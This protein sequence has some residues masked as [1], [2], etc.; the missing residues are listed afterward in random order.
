MKWSIVTYR[1]YCSRNTV[2]H[3]LI[4]LVLAMHDN[5][6]LSIISLLGTKTESSLDK[7]G[8]ENSWRDMS[9]RVSVYL[10]WRSY[11][12]MCPHPLLVCYASF[13]T[14]QNAPKPWQAC[15]GHWLK[16]P[17]CV[18]Y[19]THPKTWPTLS[20]RLRRVWTSVSLWA[21]WSFFNSRFH[22]YLTSWKMRTLTAS[23]IT[24]ILFF[25]T[26][27]I[28]Q[29]NHSR[30]KSLCQMS[31]YKQRSTLCPSSQPYHMLDSG[32]HMQLTEQ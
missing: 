2:C 12:Q 18:E 17:Q 25:K 1:C 23:Q 11:R 6:V 5:S 27:W 29:S 30:I 26:C 31:L 15:L 4:K 21:K 16:K 32:G 20:M 7:Q 13:S 8:Y 9:P 3:S 22:C 14:W 19:S 24:S 10:S 28:S